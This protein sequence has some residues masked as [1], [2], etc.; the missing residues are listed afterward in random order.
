[1]KP[2]PNSQ[3]P[4]RQAR[5]PFFNNFNSS[6]A[7][8][9]NSPPLD[10]PQKIPPP[11]VDGSDLSRNGS[12]QSS[13]ISSLN[14]EEEEE[15]L[16]RQVLRKEEATLPKAYGF[17]AAEAKLGG[18]GGEASVVSNCQ[19]GWLAGLIDSGRKEGKLL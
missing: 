4:A 12:N 10:A 11:R 5:E 16:Y 19:N 15:A 8:Q 1:M 7:G 9:D 6:S 2:R 13:R 14:N 18:G 3:Q 17:H